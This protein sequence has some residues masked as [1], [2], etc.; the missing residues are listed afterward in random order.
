VTESESF[1]NINTTSGKEFNYA[2]GSYDVTVEITVT[3]A[4]VNNSMNITGVT[5]DIISKVLN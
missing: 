3:V 1:D 4:G 5:A 2:I